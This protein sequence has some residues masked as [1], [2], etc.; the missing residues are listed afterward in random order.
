[1]NAE[2][3]EAE[4]DLDD[5]DADLRERRVAERRL[6]VRLDACGDRGEHRGRGADEDDEQLRDDR[7]D[8]RSRAPE[9]VAARVD[10]ERAVI[11]RVEGVGPSIARG[12]HPENGTRAL[13]PAAASKEERDRR[14][15][16]V[17][18]ASIATPAP[19]REQ[20]GEVPAADEVMKTST[21]ATSIEASL[22]R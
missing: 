7:L 3:A 17:D 4:R 2:R 5:D 21:A 11:D 10:R 22:T 16:D 14:G 9:E 8:Q 15:F 20:R 12:S 18:R 6:H 19:T 13:L 1:M